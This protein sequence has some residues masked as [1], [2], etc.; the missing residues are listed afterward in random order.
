MN[1][2]SGLEEPGDERYLHVFGYE[3]LNFH[4]L[5]K[6]KALTVT[7]LVDRADPPDQLGGPSERGPEG[8]CGVASP[9][10][11]HDIVLSIL[12][13]HFK[14]SRTLE[15]L[16]GQL[17]AEDGV[18][19]GPAALAA[20]DASHLDGGGVPGER[21]HARLEGGGGSVGAPGD[22][23]PLAVEA[24]R[25]RQ[26]ADAD[27]AQQGPAKRRAPASLHRA[28]AALARR[29]LVRPSHVGCR[30][31]TGPVR[32]FTPRLHRNS[33]GGTVQCA[34]SGHAPIYLAIWLIC[35]LSIVISGGLTP[36]GCGVPLSVTRCLVI[37]D[38]G[39]A[40]FI[41]AFFSV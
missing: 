39:L 31:A 26:A 4:A 24:A 23:R 21:L 34:S 16:L 2:V 32:W 38:N 6:H 9:L 37:V 5:I 13:R 7:R 35:E 19:V 15:V 11:E 27:E 36:S 8:N 41:G 25:R 30:G 12:Q 40:F 14:T 29:S 1:W 22:V 3:E 10:C 28:I 20:K 18:F 17:E 33:R